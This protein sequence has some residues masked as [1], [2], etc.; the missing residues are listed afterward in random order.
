MCRV[1]CKIFVR[2]NHAT[3]KQHAVILKA[4]AHVSALFFAHHKTCLIECTVRHPT[5]F[6]IQKG[7]TMIPCIHVNQGRKLSLLDFSHDFQPQQPFKHLPFADCVSSG[8]EACIKLSLTFLSHT[9]NTT[10]AYIHTNILLT[11]TSITCARHTTDQTLPTALRSNVQ[12]CIHT[13]MHH[14]ALASANS[15]PVLALSSPLFW[16][17]RS[18]TN[19]SSSSAPVSKKP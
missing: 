10:H 9:T 13:D 15:K 11:R 4:F 12:T 18:S 16:N 5:I 2:S 6:Q 3:V 19:V 7:R 1:L 14:A 17:W 8:F